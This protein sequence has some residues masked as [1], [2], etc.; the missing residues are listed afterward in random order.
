MTLD[1][2]GLKKAAEARGGDWI[3]TSTGR[4]MKDKA[5]VSPW[6]T[7]I[8]T[9]LIRL[10]SEGFSSGAIAK[11]LNS[12]HGSDF[13]RSAVMGKVHRLQLDMSKPS[14]PKP[15]TISPSRSAHQVWMD[16]EIEAMIK[17]KDLGADAL[18][19]LIKRSAKAIYRK[20]SGLGIKLGGP[21]LAR[22]DKPTTKPAPQYVSPFP[23]RVMT[24][25]EIVGGVPLMKAV[26]CQCREVLGFSDGDYVFCGKPTVSETSS[27]CGGHYQKNVQP[28]GQKADRSLKRSVEHYGRKGS[29]ERPY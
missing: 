2:E 16:T 4:S 20:A 3:T 12:R 27:W 11:A 7:M 23:E 28:Q 24:C 21:S 26:R 5:Y 1:I 6:S 17:Y 14:A 8:I 15:A 19:R 18:S 10:V 25:E 9:D 22:D 13:S 29:V